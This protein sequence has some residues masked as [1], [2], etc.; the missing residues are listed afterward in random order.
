MFDAIVFNE[1]LE[2]FD[3]PLSVVLRWTKS[4]AADGIVIVSMFDGLNTARSIKIWRSIEARFRTVA[5]TQVRN[6]AGYSWTI[7]VLRPL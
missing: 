7:R 4:L 1:V 2:Y 6:E 5:S 3:D